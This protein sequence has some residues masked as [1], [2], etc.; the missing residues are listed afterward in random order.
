M[1]LGPECA[2][3]QHSTVLIRN[4]CD[5][6]Y[7]PVFCDCEWTI[8]TMVNVLSINHDYDLISNKSTGRA[9][10]IY[11]FTACVCFGTQ[12]PFDAVH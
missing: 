12:L 4:Q 7:I 11:S 3:G 9:L 1:V 6:G 10:L 8:T 2:V 5:A